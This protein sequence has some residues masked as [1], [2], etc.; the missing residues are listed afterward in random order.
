MCS[1]RKS[2]K[3]FYQVSQVYDVAQEENPEAKAIFLT[4]TVRNCKANELSKVIK[5]LFLA[6]QNFAKNR[7]I[8]KAGFLGWFRALEVTY[9]RKQDTYHPHFHVIMLADKTYFTDET[10]Y[11]HTRDIVKIWRASLGVDYDPVCDIRVVREKGEKKYKAV[12]EVAK[13]TVKDADYIFKDEQK[14]VEVVH[15]LSSSLRGRRLFAFGGAMR[16]IAKRLKMDKPGEGD[17]VNINDEAEMREEIADALILYNWDFG[18]REY[19]K[20][21]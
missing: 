21:A 18:L 19:Y 5:G 15:A 17:L 16:K 8:L 2:I 1:W 3:T 14:T 11:L 6:W 10:K 7:R 13:Y 4:L 9:N 12:A 20:R